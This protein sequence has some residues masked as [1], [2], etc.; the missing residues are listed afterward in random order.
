MV[1][2]VEK[3]LSW[4]FTTQV[5]K[6]IRNLQACVRTEPVMARQQLYLKYI[7]QKMIHITFA[8]L[9]H[10]PMHFL[11]HYPTINIASFHFGKDCSV[12]NKPFLGTIWPQM[13]KN[14]C[15]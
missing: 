15:R 9:Y 4:A 13:S 8:I 11:S 14:S 12:L 1:L 7:E 10:F 6:K 5:I 2:I 3:Q